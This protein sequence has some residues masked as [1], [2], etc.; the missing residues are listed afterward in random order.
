MKASHAVGAAL[1]VLT[2][3][4]IALMLLR[5]PRGDADGWGTPA[6]P[7]DLPVARTLNLRHPA[8]VALGEMLAAAG[9]RI[10]DHLGPKTLTVLLPPHLPEDALPASVG[11]LAPQASRASLGLTA[12]LRSLR[13]DAP[14]RIRIQLTVP[15]ALPA[16]HAFLAP[17]S[18]D[19]VV[20]PWPPAVT[21]SLTAPRIR[22]LL[23]DPG[24]PIRAVDVVHDISLLTAASRADLAYGPG[25][26]HLPGLDG[27]G[28]TVAVIDNALGG[29]D[30]TVH[31][32]LRGALTH[33]TVPIW[34]AGPTQGNNASAHGS[35][36]AGIIGAQGLEDGEVRGMAP[37]ARLLFQKMANEK[38]QLVFSTYGFL[39][40]ITNGANVI[41][42]SW[43]SGIYGEKTYYDA[44]A[45]DIDKT[46]WDNPETLMLFAVGNSNV[47]T[48]SYQTQAKNILS[49]GRLNSS[50][51]APG[52]YNHGGTADGRW[53]PLLL[54]PGDGIVSLAP[55][56]G[57]RT[58]SGT[59]MATPI[60]SGTAVCLRQF[61]RTQAGIPAPSAALLRSATLL[62]AEPLTAYNPSDT[63][64][65]EANT[66]T[67]FGALRPAKYLTDPKLRFGFR[68]RIRLTKNGTD[69]AFTFTVPESAAGTADVLVVL[70]WID[71][72][73]PVA[74]TGGVT[75]DTAKCINDY[76]LMLRTPS[77]ETFSCGDALN[78]NER[79]RIPDATAGTYTVTVRASRIAQDGNGNLAA[80]S[81]YAPAAD[82]DGI[83]FQ[84]ADGTGGSA[85]LTVLPP[86]GTHPP[87]DHP[88]WPGAGYSL[89]P[90]GCSLSPSV[91]QSYATIGETTEDGST[92]TLS[93]DT[94]ELTAPV[95]WTLIYEDGEV[96]QGKGLTPEFILDRDATFR[97][98]FTFPGAALKLR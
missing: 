6:L 71:P 87:L 91:G 4:A 79:I 17:A 49:V 67:G 20:S 82:T 42:C 33:A 14:L 59:S 73:G 24:L 8:D 29:S 12:A 95:G 74:G 65:A 69:H 92:Y 19:C 58:D 9:I 51:T 27:Y 10:L 25:L 46:V 52:I 81:W 68:D 2:A 11:T 77:G 70:S 75:A 34:A 1:I 76:D 40:P 35:H 53:S 93:L 54:T 57:V 31:P 94:R 98:H 72:P 50:R 36:V 80:V 45:H 60:A 30:G 16:M 21:C 38:G 32:D 78:T 22:R 37:R 55:T 26:D 18:P 41:S 5:S 89:H 43:G 84:P 28:E 48:T 47:T 13:D 3:A 15:E 86:E 96:R 66:T 64:H 97:W 23:D 63:P 90:A 61:L 88:L 7:A 56:A 85:K 39:D 44:E 83:R 62:M